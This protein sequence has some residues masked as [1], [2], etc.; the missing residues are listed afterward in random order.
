[1]QLTIQNQGDTLPTKIVDVLMSIQAEGILHDCFFS[2]GR[3]LFQRHCGEKVYL[4]DYA[5]K[6]PRPY[7]DV[8]LQDYRVVVC[9]VCGDQQTKEISS[10][11]SP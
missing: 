5:K 6:I 7:N 8:H 4:F 11:S 2:R 9:R 10:P 3:A 1:M